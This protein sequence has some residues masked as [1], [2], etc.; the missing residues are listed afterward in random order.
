MIIFQKSGFIISSY[1]FLLLPYLQ[2]ILETLII[3][4]LF[5]Y[6]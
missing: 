6:Y 3:E 2:I 1:L 5:N 4:F